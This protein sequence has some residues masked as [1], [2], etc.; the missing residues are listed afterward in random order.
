MS[1]GNHRG[2]RDR[3]LQRQ[4][5][6]VFWM[7]TGSIAI[8]ELAASAKPDAIVIDAQHGLWDR[9]AIEH[10]VGLASRHVPVL[11]RTAENTPVAA[12]QALDAGADGI[13]VPLIEDAEAA[14]RAVAAAR[15]PP[16]GVRSG[17]G[18]RPVAQGFANYYAEADAGTVVGIMIE[19]KRGVDNAR[20]IARRPASISCRSGRAISHSRSALFHNPIPGLTTPAARSSMPAMRRAFRAGSSRTVPTVPSSAAPKATRLSSPQTISTLL[21]PDFPLLSTNSAPRRVGVARH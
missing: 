12:G 14:A 20:A 6:G 18:V 2:L 21:L 4:P 15:F 5:L 8:M 3:L 17:G 19:T 16:H 9:L 13:I 1:Q 7:S 11:V 10:A